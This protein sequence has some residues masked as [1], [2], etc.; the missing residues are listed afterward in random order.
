MT[1][2]KCPDYLTIQSVVDNEPVNQAVIEH[3]EH[4]T[5]CRKKEEEIR[6]IVLQA[7][8]LACLDRL[9]AEFYKRLNDNAA[10]RAFPALPVALLVFA[11]AITSAYFIDPG[12]FY[13]WVTVGITGTIA[14]FM[15]AFFGLL[16][17]GIN[18]EPVW[19]ILFLAMLVLIE[20][21][22]LSGIKRLEGVTK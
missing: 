5:D 18:M 19:I 22:I 8:Q 15:D 2:H 6:S 16:Y 17:F 10:N 9:P 11:A 13:W 1:D 3:L 12:Y 7:N 20:L 14:L 4:C 21:T